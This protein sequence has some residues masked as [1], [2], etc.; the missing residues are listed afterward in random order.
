VYPNLAFTCPDNRD[1]ITMIYYNNP[2]LP[3]K[4]IPSLKL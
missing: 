2:R 4:N 3:S 1:L